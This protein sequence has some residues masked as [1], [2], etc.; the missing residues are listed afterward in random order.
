MD[1]TDGTDGYIMVNATKSKDVKY[2]PG[3]KIQYQ[4]Q[5]FWSKDLKRHLRFNG[6]MFD[7]VGY[8][9]F[10]IDDDG[11]PYW[12]LSKYK[13]H[14]GLIGRNTESLVLVNATNGEIEEY[15]IDDV[16]SWVDRVHPDEFV[17]T[18]LRDW[19]NYI[20]GWWNPS[21]KDEVKPT[22]GTSVVY[23]S[24]GECYY[25][26]GITSVGKDGTIL[27]FI[28]TNTRDKSTTYYRMAGATETKAKNSAEGA[29]QE[30]GYVASNPRPYNI[31]GELTYVMALKDAEGLIK[32]VGLVSVANYEIV[33]VGDNVREAIRAFKTRMNTFIGTDVLSSDVSYIT[34]EGV[35]SRI[36]QDAETGY[37]YILLED[38]DKIISLTSEIS[39]EVLLTEPKDVIVVRSFPS[40]TT[41]I[42][43]V[44]FDNKSIE[45]VMSNEQKEL[46]NEQESIVSSKIMDNINER[47]ESEWKE[48]TTEQKDSILQ[49]LKN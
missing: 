43:G 35:V 10:E 8:K 31:N 17:E 15:D 18:Q 27:G 9:E 7:Y 48:F 13:K 30:K 22:P 2:V 19:G 11:N 29:V 23:G 26:T 37:Y 3:F 24:D 21:N 45:L 49:S 14:V 47:V 25:Y 42:D 20:H 36:N 41:I 32:N 4:P 44:Y 28:L 6:Y 5:A 33:A 46:E 38:G 12:I 16:P 40:N 39:E 1:N 34:Y